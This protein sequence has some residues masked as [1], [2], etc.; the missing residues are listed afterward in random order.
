MQGF[1]DIKGTAELS[2]KDVGNI[3]G[4]LDGSRY[5]CPASAASIL[6]HTLPVLVLVVTVMQVMLRIV[7]VAACV[8]KHDIAVALKHV[9]VAPGSLGTPHPC[10]A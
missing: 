8:V 4:A 2:L 9:L 3:K 6:F 10:A 7:S 1:T 5:R